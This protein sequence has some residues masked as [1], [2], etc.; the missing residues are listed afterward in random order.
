MFLNFKSKKSNLPIKI[1]S[2]SSSS[3]SDLDP[4]SFKQVV[5]DCCSESTAHGI[6]HIFRRQNIALKLF[7]LACTLTSAVVCAWLVAKT[8]TDYNSYETVTKSQ[9][10]FETPT[11]FPTVSI[12]SQNMFTTDWGYYYVSEYNWENNLESNSEWLSRSMFMENDLIK[13]SLGV[14]FLD[15]A[16]TD[17]D[18][19]SMGIQIGDMILLCYFN[20]FGCSSYDFYW[21]WDPYYG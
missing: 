6:P 9:M 1:M 12:C 10:I 19:K 2:E 7:W 20:N 8:I 14:H 13:Y 21:Y 3:S 4:P 18:R 15:S 5:S 11:L 17:D 16:F